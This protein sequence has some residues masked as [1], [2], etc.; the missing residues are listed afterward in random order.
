VAVSVNLH[1]SHRQHTGGL[2]S[3]A[4]EGSTVGECL[5]RLV[6]AHPGL[7]DA[8]FDAAGKLRNNIEIYLN[9]ESTYPEELGKQTRDG[10]KIHIAV[11]LAGG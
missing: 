10:D 2:E 7:R 9:M 3:V 4:V 8:L 6:A 11:M 5:E 1:S